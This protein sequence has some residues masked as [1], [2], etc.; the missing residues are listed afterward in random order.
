[1]M[2]CFPLSG[3]LIVGVKF[4]GSVLKWTELALSIYMKFKKWGSLLSLDQDGS[5]HLRSVV[6]G[7]VM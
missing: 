5:W 2:V 1:M 3:S 4:K 6:F 7:E